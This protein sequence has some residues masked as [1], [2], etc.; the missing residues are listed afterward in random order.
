LVFIA[1][2]LLAAYGCSISDYRR[3][4][5]LPDL[6]APSGWGVNIHFT[7][8]APGEA[9][10]LAQSGFKWIRNDFAW[11]AIERERGKYDFSAYDRLAAALKRANIRPLFILDYGNDLYQKGSP[12]SPASREAFCR[13][14]EASVRHFGGQGVVWEM[15]NEPNIGFWQ[16]KPDVGEYIQLAKAVGETIRRTSPEEW[17][18]GPATSG[19]DW[20]FLQR[21][22]DSGL[23]SYW[24]GVSVHPYRGSEPETVGDDWGRLRA[25][26][27][28][29][30]P[31]GK[32][33]EMFSSEWGYSDI[34]NGLGAERQADY[35]SRQYLAN[36][37]GGV[38]LSI[39]YD[40]KNDGVSATDPECHFGMLAEDLRPKPAYDAVVALSA[41]LSGYTYKFRAAQ[42][43]DLDY[44]LV[45]QKANEVKYAGW[46]T[47]PGTRTASLHLGP[48]S[49]RVAFNSRPRVWTAAHP[50]LAV[51]SLRLPEVFEIRDAKRTHEF[52]SSILGSIDPHRL[53]ASGSRLFFR[54][55][56]ANGSLEQPVDAGNRSAVVNAFENRIDGNWS[57]TP[58]KL[59]VTAVSKG[60]RTL[61]QKV[62][63]VQTQ[64]VS[65]NLVAAG[66]KP[67]VVV[68]NLGGRHFM[69]V[70]ENELPSS[71]PSGFEI[72]KGGEEVIPI[73]PGP[74]LYLRVNPL[75]EDGRVMSGPSVSDT[76]IG[77]ILDGFDG[78]AV[79]GIQNSGASGFALTQDGD[80]KVGVTMKMKAVAAADGPLKGSPATEIDYQFQPGW[81]FL[82]LRPIGQQAPIAGDSSVELNMFVK[83][84]ASRNALRMRFTDATGQTFQPTYGNLGWLGWKF[85]SFKLDGHDSG[86]WGGA[87]DGVV[88]FPIRIATVV[89][90]DSTQRAGKPSQI[91]VAGMAL[92]GRKSTAELL[93]EETL[94][95][96]RR[97]R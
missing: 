18:I 42:D 36:L 20:N 30:T 28:A 47:A 43:S 53:Q 21:C 46:T 16:P 62:N 91:S 97:R 45:F 22:L 25:M 39:V 12:R 34:S 5:P 31:A 7:D 15:W 71:M 26:I 84:D 2:I 33:V 76:F 83:S 54:L 40:W 58:S 60:G 57:D 80:P 77:R 69:V 50:A 59:V 29:K 23:L 64:P 79:P 63:C 86:Y 9:D 56:D 85:V 61:S 90:V 11:S 37:M 96:R 27:D 94:A 1:P 95:R 81:K 52:L 3:Q 67:W 4:Y 89:L 51:G 48:D 78:I 65:L 35:I 32:H 70:V 13:F 74:R 68:H 8:P 44:V 17:F 66:G 6:T 75:G 41:A 93:E 10:K 38:P 55:K 14:V 87:N 73:Q 24:D 19:F 92:V 82:E 88:H 49:D 72:D